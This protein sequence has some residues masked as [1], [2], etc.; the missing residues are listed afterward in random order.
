MLIRM[1]QN[2]Q[3]QEQNLNSFLYLPYIHP[4]NAF[5]ETMYMPTR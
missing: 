5:Q 1:Q 2:V 4:P 3:V